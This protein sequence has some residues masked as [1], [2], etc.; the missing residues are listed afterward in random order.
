MGHRQRLLAVAAA[1]TVIVAAAA[2]SVQAAGA[3]QPPPV[4]A[5]DLLKMLHHPQRE[6]D[7]TTYTLS[8]P[9]AG[10]ATVVWRLSN[11]HGAVI[12]KGLTKREYA[13]TANV[14]VLFSKAGQATLTG[15]PGAHVLATATFTPPDGK[16][17][18]ASLNTPAG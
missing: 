17:V 1:L 4:R 7:R 11:S 6:S 3:N 12:G 15:H 16:T 5:S 2:P 14:V 9:D 10:V 13:G 18:Q 8:W